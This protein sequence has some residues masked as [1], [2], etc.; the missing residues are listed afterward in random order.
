MESYGGCTW[1][2][3]SLKGSDAVNQ[4][5]GPHDVCGKIL[6]IELNFLK[7]LKK[8]ACCFCRPK[9][10][11]LLQ[12]CRSFPRVMKTLDK[13]GLQIISNFPQRDISEGV[14]KIKCRLHSS[15]FDVNCKWTHGRRCVRGNKN[16]W[17][18]NVLVWKHKNLCWICRDLMF[19]WIIDGSVLVHVHVR[20]CVCECVFEC[21]RR[22]EWGFL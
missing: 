2:R 7:P 6:D 20:A 11:L 5:W 10:K 14:D 4:W 9:Q 22:K 15:T 12:Q 17:T 13:A 21:G 8:Q 19:T 1:V 3:I 18:E 16:S